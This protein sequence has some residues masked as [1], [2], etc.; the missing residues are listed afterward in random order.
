MIPI[1]IER[2]ILYYVISVC[3]TANLPALTILDSIP[4][5]PEF[6]NVKWDALIKDVEEK[7]TAHYLQKFSGFGIEALSYEGNIEG[8]D[9]L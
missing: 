3:F 7:E 4:A 6:R 1:K 9:A 5:L 8:L 2:V